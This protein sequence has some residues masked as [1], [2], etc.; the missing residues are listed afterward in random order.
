MVG[1]ANKRQLEC[2]DIFAVDLTTKSIFLVKPRVPINLP[3]KSV[4]ITTG[5]T[6]ILQTKTK[7][8]NVKKE[9]KKETS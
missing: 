2:Y 5:S 8:T 3:F 9:E 4:L 1:V 6:T 7:Y